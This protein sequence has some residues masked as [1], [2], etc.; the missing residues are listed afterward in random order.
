MQGSLHPVALYILIRGGL[1]AGQGTHR[2][3]ATGMP[4]LRHGAVS[5]KALGHGVVW[6]RT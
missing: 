1:A 2:R 5:A 4:V 6:M 3:G